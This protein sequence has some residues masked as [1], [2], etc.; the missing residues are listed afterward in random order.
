MA[1]YKLGL[2]MRPELKQ[3]W[4]DALRSGNYSQG[5]AFLRDNNDNFCCLGVLCDVADA[6]EWQIDN[7]DT[8]FVFDGWQLDDVLNE[9]AL[10]YFQLDE[11]IADGL[12]ALNDGSYCRWIG[13]AKKL[14]FAEIADIIEADA[15]ETTMPDKEES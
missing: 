1:T 12:M 9:D 15:I 4:I 6:G 11:P 13:Y 10:E 3:K 5:E 8:Y 2:T 14:S 7:N